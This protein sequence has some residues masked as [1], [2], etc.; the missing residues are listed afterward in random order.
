ML[1]YNHL[2]TIKGY[3]SMG[4]AYILAGNTIVLCGVIISYL[5]KLLKKYRWKFTLNW[6]KQSWD[7]KVR[8]DWYN[9][10]RKVQKPRNHTDLRFRKLSPLHWIV[11]NNLVLRW[12]KFPSKGGTSDWLVSQVARKLMSKHLACL[13]VLQS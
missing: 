2:A 10:K 9:Q 1:W 11:E 6:I 7:V 8:R 13:I 3:G 12:F 5:L 4:T